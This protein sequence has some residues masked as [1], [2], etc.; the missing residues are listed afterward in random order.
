[1]ASTKRKSPRIYLTYFLHFCIVPLVVSL[2]TKFEVCKFSR[3]T[4]LV[5]VQ[6]Y[7]SRSREVGH[8]PSDLL[9]HFLVC[10][11][12]VHEHTKFEVPSCTHSGNIEEVSKL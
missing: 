2:C 12:G 11:L 6:N 3:F 8:T 4:D 5:G 9:L 1:M 7:K 10:R